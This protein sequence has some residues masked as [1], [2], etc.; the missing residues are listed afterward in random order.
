[1][2]AKTS[3]GSGLCF[4]IS[5]RAASTQ[6]TIQAWS[7]KLVYPNVS[8]FN[9]VDSIKRRNEADAGCLNFNV[10]FAGTLV[11]VAKAGDLGSRSG[12]PGWVNKQRDE[13]GSAL[14]RAKGVR[15]ELPG[16][17]GVVKTER[18]LVAAR[19]NA[20]G[21]EGCYVP[22]LQVTDY[23]AFNAAKLVPA[24]TDIVFQQHY[25]TI[26]T[27]M[28]DRPEVGFTIAKEA[29]QRRSSPTTRSRP[30]AP[31]ARFSNFA[32]RWELGKPSGRDFLQRGGSTGLDDAAYAPARKGHDLQSR[33][34]DRGEA[35][36]F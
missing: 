34:P 29:P 21:V 30:W 20:G 2:V 3:S 27:A 17:P 7:F 28:T 19:F 18:E 31:T 24:N 8:I 26:G 16:V 35:D 9:G 36:C 13:S 25:T 33:I 14:P 1:M 32:Q 10:T 22:G 5:N 23:R 15:N 11:D 6:C 4:R 12:V